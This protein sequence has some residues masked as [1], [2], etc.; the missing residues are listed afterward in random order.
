LGIILAFVGRVNLVNLTLSLPAD[1]VD[2]MKEIHLKEGRT[3]S[4]QV[5]FAVDLV[6]KI[7]DLKKEASR[8]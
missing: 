5:L 1:L 3:I 2:R 8:F 4:E 7:E 6:H